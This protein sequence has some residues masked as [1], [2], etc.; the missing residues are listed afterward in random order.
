VRRI[1]AIVT[2]LVQGVS[3][4][5]STR[6]EAT[7]LGLAGWVRNR[8]DGAV[9]LEAEGP[10][11]QIEKLVA[12]CQHGPSYARVDGVAVEER[13]ATGEDTAFTVRR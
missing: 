7:R 5:Y 12:W 13:T 3:Y 10:D 11:A 6:I 4:R 8:D 2:G 9:E 1:H